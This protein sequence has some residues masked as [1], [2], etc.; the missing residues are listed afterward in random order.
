[1]AK[2]PKG[3]SSSKKRRPRNGKAG[4]WP[5]D[6]QQPGTCTHGTPVTEECE[7]CKADTAKGVEEFNAAVARGE[8]DEQGYTPNE[9][10]AQARKTKTLR[11][12]NPVETAAEHAPDQVAQKPVETILG[13]FNADA[14][15][16]RLFQKRDAVQKAFDQVTRKKIDLK[17]AQTILETEESGLQTM[18]DEF[19]AQRD[20]LETGEQ[21]M[22]KVVDEPHIKSPRCQF[23]KEDFEACPICRGGHASLNNEATVWGHAHLTEAREIVQRE[24]EAEADR[25]K[26]VAAIKANGAASEEE[27]PGIEAETIAN[28]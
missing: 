10:K 3:K 5:E 7:G 8:M 21:P 28:G 15:M 20:R 23:E 4:A 11:A 16:E 2:E 13:P 27:G 19:R 25:Q 18:I 24:R 6:T 12:K 26:D 22:L 17:T 1:M 9:R 14:A